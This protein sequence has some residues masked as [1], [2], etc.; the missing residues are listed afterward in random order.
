MEKKNE[1]K[2]PTTRQQ[3]RGIDTGPREAL[4]KYAILL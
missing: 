2:N 4:L 3:Q 1:E